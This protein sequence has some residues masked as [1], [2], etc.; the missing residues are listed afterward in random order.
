MREANTAGRDCSIE[1]KIEPLKCRGTRPYLSVTKPSCRILIIWW[2][3]II[4]PTSETL[5]PFDCKFSTSWGVQ[6][7][8]KLSIAVAMCNSVDLLF[9]FSMSSGEPIEPITARNSQKNALNR[10]GAER[11][12]KDTNQTLVDLCSIDRISARSVDKSK[13]K[14]I[15][16]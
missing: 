6:S 3:H 12:A 15:R 9:S 7:S 4:L 1:H 2:H 8:H 13:W 16:Y 10:M 11:F 5:L 14:T